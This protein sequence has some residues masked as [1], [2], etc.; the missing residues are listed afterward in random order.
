MRLFSIL[1]LVF[2]SSEA[3]GQ[4]AVYDNRVHEQ[5]RFVNSV[6]N[7]SIENLREFG[8]LSRV[9]ADFSTVTLEDRARFIGTQED[10]GDR[11]L[12]Q[13]HFIACQGLRNLRLKTLEQSE[14]LLDVIQ[15]RRDQINDLIQDSRGIQE[16]A[17]A[18]QRFQFELQGIQALM[19]SDAM[20]LQVLMSAYKQREKMYEVQMTEARRVTDTRPPGTFNLGAVPFLP[21][22][23]R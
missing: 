5:L 17:G 3:F 18:L 4:W 23:M 13:Q 16:R 15:A 12:N 9:R 7:A 1:L 20:R 8:D 21:G 19:Q 2:S 22:L 6:G 10:C 11:N 14:A